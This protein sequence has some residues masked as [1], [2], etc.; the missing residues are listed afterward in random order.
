[1]FKIFIDMFMNYRINITGNSFVMSMCDLCI[2]LKKHRFQLFYQ[3]IV[4]P[5]KS[6]KNG[7]WWNIGITVIYGPVIQKVYLLV[8]NLYG[9]STKDWRGF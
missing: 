2:P 1:M 6:H 7:S 9:G 5:T 4:I 8:R 3:I